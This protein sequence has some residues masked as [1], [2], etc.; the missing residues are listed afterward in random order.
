M[1]VQSSQPGTD[2][3]SAAQALYSNPSGADNDQD[4]LD[5]LDDRSETSRAH[6]GR[7]QDNDGDYGA[8]DE[9]LSPDPSEDEDEGPAPVR[10]CFWPTRPTLMARN[11][12]DSTTSSGPFPPPSHLL[13]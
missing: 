1:G 3:A 10:V 12:L 7:H 11:S 4:E 13:Q 6:A 9:T 8:D 2:H 5:E